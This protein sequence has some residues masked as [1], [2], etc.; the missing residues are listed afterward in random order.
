LRRRR[1]RSYAAF[2]GP[3]PAGLSLKPQTPNTS[4]ATCQLWCSSC[5]P[6]QTLRCS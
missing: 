5:F 6:R 2:A 1:R 3:L 4:P